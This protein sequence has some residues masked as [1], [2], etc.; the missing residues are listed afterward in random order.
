MLHSLLCDFCHKNGKPLANKINFDCEIPYRNL[1][2]VHL[3]FDLRKHFLKILIAPDRSTLLRFLISR[4]W[5]RLGILLR[6]ERPL[7]LGHRLTISVS[8]C[9]L[10]DS[11]PEFRL[12]SLRHWLASFRVDIQYVR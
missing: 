12:S 3:I 11:W 5:R 2:I 1:R 6:A 9:V 8:C 7:N 4:A 10:V